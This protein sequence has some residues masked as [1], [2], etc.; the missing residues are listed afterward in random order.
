MRGFIGL[1]AVLVGV[2]VI[3]W[4]MSRTLPH[5]Q[6]TLQTGSQTRQQV[7]VIAGKDP[8]TGL[9]ANSS[10]DLVGLT[11]GG[12][13][14]GLLV[15]RIQPGGAYEKYF[16]LKRDDVIVAFESQAFRREIKELSSEE[17]AR[18]CILDT[19]QKGGSLIVVRNEQKL[20]LPQTPPAPAGKQ[21]TDP[22][23]QQLDAIQNI[24]R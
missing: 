5:T 4:I 2:G 24:P 19:Y 10:A 22:L 11:Q 20:T 9:P 21:S 13:L 23:Q 8:E 16:G 3:V 17:E 6:Q 15:T 12:R 1:A 18:D 7:N 14:T